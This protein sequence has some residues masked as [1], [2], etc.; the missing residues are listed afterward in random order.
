[1]KRLMESALRAARHDTTV[2][3]SG[4]TGVGKEVMASFIHRNSDR[5]KKKL[6]KVN[7]SAIPESL[8][9][10][11]FFGYEK[12][13]FTGANV[14]GKIGLFEEADGGTLFL[15]EIGE[16]PVN[17]QSKLLRVLQEQEIQRI[18]GVTPVKI[19]VRIIA[20]TNRDLK[21][22]AEQG[23]FRKDLYYRL[24]II[25]LVVPA[26]RERKEDLVPLANDFLDKLNLL[27]NEN[28]RFSKEA[29]EAFGRYNWPG[30]VRELRNVIERVFVMTEGQLIRDTD[31]PAEIK[32]VHDN[33]SVV[34]GDHVLKFAVAKLEYAM[35]QEAFEKHGNVR[36]AAKALGIDASTFVRK[37][38]KYIQELSL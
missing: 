4:E 2:L 29:Y 22:M 23:L 28:K 36:D 34:S 27:Y 20:A 9:E 30:N 3:I 33:A 37:R 35:I 24:N 38:T 16:L 10:S 32:A 11:E 14:N 18:G 6:V 26:L 5:R 1:M 31:L 17:L 7:C 12:G 21:E 13:A 19:D 15:D 8:M 25:P